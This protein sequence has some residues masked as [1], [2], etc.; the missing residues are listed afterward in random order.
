MNYI[1]K[2]L[3]KGAPEYFYKQPIMTVIKSIGQFFWKIFK[4]I[5][6]RKKDCCK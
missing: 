5:F 6:V 3:I 2:A 4:A 1:L